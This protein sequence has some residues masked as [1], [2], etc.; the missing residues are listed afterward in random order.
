MRKRRELRSRRF[1]ISHNKDLHPNLLVKQYNK[2]MY[3]FYV[4]EN[5]LGDLYY[6]NTNNLKRRLWEHQEGRSFATK[7]SE[8]TLIYYEA[9]RDKRD[10][11]DRE[12]KI[13]NNGGTKPHLKK[14]ISR[15]RQF[16]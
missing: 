12:W 5:E 11:K 4:I 6:G 8:W 10:A 13:K 7:G 3:Y 2:N 16:D 9:Y 15:S 14:R 1:L